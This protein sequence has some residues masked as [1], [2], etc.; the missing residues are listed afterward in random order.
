MK[1][2]SKETKMS[3]TWKKNNE[4]DREYKLFYPH[5]LQKKEKDGT[6]EISKNPSKPTK[7]FNLRTITANCCS[8]QAIFLPDRTENTRSL[9]LS[10]SNAH[11]L[12]HFRKKN[13]Q[14][15]K[16]G[17]PNE[18]VVSSRIKILPFASSRFQQEVRKNARRIDEETH[19]EQ[20][21][22]E[23]EGE[24]QFSILYWHVTVID[25]GSQL[26]RRT[27]Q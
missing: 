6:V 12:R 7:F 18:K 13:R 22:R 27:V 25:G 3:R 10:E 1:L 15:E 5:I 11:S 23:R 9:R 19:G 2:T 21:E 17:G 4:R 16:N 8:F 26:P 20:R 24:S 14:N